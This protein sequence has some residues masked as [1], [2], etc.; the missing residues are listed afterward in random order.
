MHLGKTLPTPPLCLLRF[1]FVLF[2]V[3]FCVFCC[4]FFVFF[5]R[6]FFFFRGG[7]VGGCYFFLNEYLFQAYRLTLSVIGLLDLREKKRLKLACTAAQFGKNPWH[8][9]LQC[10]VD[11]RYLQ[12]QGT[13]KHFEIC[14]PRHIRFDLQN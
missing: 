4:C 13:L 8:S 14:V 1:C 2:F 10:T 9:L 5:F 12:F 7:G 3:F 11:S 6:F